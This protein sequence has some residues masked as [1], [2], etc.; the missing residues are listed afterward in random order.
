MTFGVGMRLRIQ[1]LVSNK[2]PQAY[3]IT[4]STAKARRQGQGYRFI[5]SLTTE[6]TEDTEG[7]ENGESTPE[8][9]LNCLKQGVGAIL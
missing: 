6:D 9:Q 8:K 1:Y 4:I 2:R 3:H 7:T 5:F